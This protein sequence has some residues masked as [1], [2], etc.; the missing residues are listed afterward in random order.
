M[1]G[2][3]RNRSSLSFNDEEV[4]PLEGAINIIDAMLVFACALIIALVINW[5]IDPTIGRE[6][7]NVNQGQELSQDTQIRNDLI[8]AEQEGEGQ[9]YERVGTVYMDPD[10]GRMFIL[11]EE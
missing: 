5:N 10:S 2:G 3:L 4:N 7:V 1:N 6:R 8:R 9:F 11:T